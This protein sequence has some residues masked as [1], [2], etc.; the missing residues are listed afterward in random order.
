MKVLK[1]ILVIIAILIAIPLLIALFVKKDYSVARS[2]I[3]NKPPQE[4][5]DYVKMLKNQDN[6]SKW[7]QMDSAM[8]KQYS[9]TDG[10]VGFVYAWDSEGKAGKGEQEIKGLIDG[11]Q[12]DTEVRFKKPFESTAAGYF[13]TEP[14]GTGNT[15]LTWAMSGHSPYPLNFMN[16]FVPGLLGGDI[17]NS[18]AR[19]KGILN[20]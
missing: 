8:I 12:V 2:V 16:L 18:L 7:N 19:L 14:E 6:F 17:D 13:K 3:I 15:K 1:V 5:Y 9:G 4:V 10:T 20:N 11:K